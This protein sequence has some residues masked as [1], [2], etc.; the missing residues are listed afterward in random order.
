[1][2]KSLFPNDGTYPDAGKDGGSGIVVLKLPSY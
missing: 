1:M 2:S